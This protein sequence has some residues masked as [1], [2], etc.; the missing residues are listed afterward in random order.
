LEDETQTMTASIIFSTL[1]SF[2]KIK[3]DINQTRLGKFLCIT[4]L[5]H[6]TNN[7][8]SNIMN[9]KRKENKKEVLIYV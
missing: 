4:L 6:M 2:R 8:V 9:M 1:S 3:K 7:A 5:P